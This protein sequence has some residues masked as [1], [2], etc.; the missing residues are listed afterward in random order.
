MSNNEVQQ[1]RKEIGELKDA[2]HVVNDRI[3]TVNNR[4]QVWTDDDY[5][6]KKQEVEKRQAVEKSIEKWVTFFDEWATA[7]KVFLWIVGGISATIAFY[8]LMFEFI[9][10]FMSK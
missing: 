7:K 4:M 8:L 9:K 5:R 10:T 1:L 3:E 6:W 2:I